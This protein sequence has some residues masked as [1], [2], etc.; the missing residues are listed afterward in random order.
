M[1]KK[2]S[3]IASYPNDEENLLT[4]DEDGDFTGTAP[5]E[6][7]QAQVKVAQEELMQLRL[8]QEEI[9][10]QQERLEMIRKKQAAFATGKRELLEKMGRSSTNIERELYNAQK[11]TEELTA[12]LDVFQRHIE[13]LRGIQPDKWQRNQTED[14]LDNAIE[15]IDDAESDFEKSTRRLENLRPVETTRR[16]GSVFKTEANGEQHMVWFQRGLAFTMPL[17]VALALGV[18]VVRLLF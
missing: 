13:V 14:E 3:S 17:I 18:I 1:A 5:V 4:F 2:N 12:T 16:S 15:A 8:R 10:R 7:V 11:L 9:E 6:D